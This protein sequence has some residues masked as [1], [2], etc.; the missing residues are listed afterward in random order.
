MISAMASQIS[1][2]SIVCITVCSGIDK[3]KHQSSR[4]FVG[5]IHRCP[6]DSPHKGPVTRKMFPL[7]DVIMIME[8]DKLAIQGDMT[9]TATVLT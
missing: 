4:A 2:V 3:R 1:S 7:D 9:S 5:E 6:V 8:D